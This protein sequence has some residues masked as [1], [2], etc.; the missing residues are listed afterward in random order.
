LHYISGGYWQPTAK[1]LYFTLMDAQNS[2]PIH[3]V[4]ALILL[5]AVLFYLFFQVNKAAEFVNAN[6][7]ANDPYDAVGSIAVQTALLISVL[8]YARA[9]RWR[10]D[11]SQKSKARLILHGNILVLASM[12]ITLCSDII[13]EIIVR[14]PNSYWV[15]FLRLELGFMLLLTVLCGVYL[16]LVFHRLPTPAPPTNLTPADAIDDL[17]S[18][19][20]IP[21]LKIRMHPPNRFVDWVARFNSD[22]LFKHMPWINPRFHPWRFTSLLALLVGLLLVV[23]QLQEGLP[24]SLKV[25]LLTAGIFISIEFFAI[26]L[27]YVILGGYLGL[28]PAF[29]KV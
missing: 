12:F 23:A 20:R 27:G 19:V 22:W 8:S 3:R 5:S 29:G 16:W 9:L 6:P 26:L 25:A 28:R 18:L 17:W 14:M 15:N 21:I 1:G 11:S 24:S 10:E 7:F 13:A 2:K 4:T